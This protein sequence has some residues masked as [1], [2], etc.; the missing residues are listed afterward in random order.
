[1][2][3]IIDG[4]AGDCVTTVITEYGIGVFYDAIDVSFYTTRVKIDVLENDFILKY[5]TE[6]I[7]SYERVKDWNGRT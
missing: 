7:E 6:K 5:V 3:L 4:N 2:G 1:M